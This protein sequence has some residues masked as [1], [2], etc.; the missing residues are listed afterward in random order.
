MIGWA[1]NGDGI[2]IRGRRKVREHAPVIARE[3]AIRQHGVGQAGNA[4]ER[5]LKIRADEHR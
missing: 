3:I 4:V 2:V 5:E 1:A